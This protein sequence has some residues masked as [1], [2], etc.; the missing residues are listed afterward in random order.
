[1]AVLSAFSPSWL[2]VL[3]R[4]ATHQLIESSAIL[5]PFGEVSSYWLLIRKA[6]GFNLSWWLFLSLYAQNLTKLLL[7]FGLSQKFIEI[8]SQC[9][10]I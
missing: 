3:I 7:I 4:L 9:I 5:S 1:L 10:N 6:W 8:V 2:A